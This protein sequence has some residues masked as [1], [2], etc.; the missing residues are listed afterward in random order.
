MLMHVFSC[1][2]WMLKLL[3]D[4]H[5]TQLHLD[6]GT[7]LV[8]NKINND[9]AVYFTT[10]CNFYAVNYYP[11]SHSFVEPFW[12]HFCTSWMFFCS[13]G[14]HSFGLSIHVFRIWQHCPN[15]LLWE[16]STRTI[17]TL[18]YSLGRE[19]TKV[20]VMTSTVEWV[21]WFCVTTWFT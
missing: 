5:M 15:R 1:F 17:L 18:L 6:N 7:T 19:N 10:M 9:S 14:H 13:Y 11:H 12:E 16:W 21:H 20:K 4:Q 2:I 8:L 3:F